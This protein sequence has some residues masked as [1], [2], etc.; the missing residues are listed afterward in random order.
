MRLTDEQIKKHLNNIVTDS[1]SETELQKTIQRSEAAFYESEAEHSLTNVEFLYQQGKYIHKRWWLL[2][3]FLLLIL[4]GIFELMDT[5]HYLQRCLGIAAP[6]FAILVLPELWKNRNADAVEVEC[7]TYFS[8]RQ[9]YAARIFL[10]TLVDLP[11]LTV[12]SF[13]VITTDK[14]IL[15]DL[16]IQFFLPYVVTCCICFQCLYSRRF[17][18][19]LFPIFLC[20]VWSGIWTQLILNEK[21]YS[22]VSLPLWYGMLTLAIFYL[23]YCI[24]RGQKDFK[25][26]LEVKPS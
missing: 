2:Q 15:Q 23:G 22:A 9:I 11:M 1:Y 5:P 13:G 4:W 24:Y 7:T 6:L 25:E 18:S 16:I 17:G 21:I 14:C 20:I 19:E 3:A 26:I 10:F 12:F 8:L